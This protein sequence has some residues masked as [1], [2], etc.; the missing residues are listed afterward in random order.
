MNTQQ[1]AYIE[2]F[3][4]RASEYGLN[5]SEAIELLKSALDPA[6]VNTGSVAAAPAKPNWN[7]RI[8]GALGM[9]TGAVSYPAMKGNEY[10]GV[11][12]K[13]GTP[14]PAK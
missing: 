5:Q 1:Q 9:P 3:V 7:E 12:G 6:T 14:A 8:L 13:A 4:K 11:M 10:K 2:G